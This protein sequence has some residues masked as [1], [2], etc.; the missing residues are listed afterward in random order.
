LQNKKKTYSQKATLRRGDLQ[1]LE[2]RAKRYRTG[3][4]KEGKSRKMI[5]A[6]SRKQPGQWGEEKS[7]EY[8]CFPRN[9]EEGGKKPIALGKKRA[10]DF[11]MQKKT[12]HSGGK[13]KK[14]TAWVHRKKKGKANLLRQDQAQKR[15]KTGRTSGS[16]MR[17]EEGGKTLKGEEDLQADYP[18][19]KKKNKREE[20]GFRQPANFKKEGEG[21]TKKGTCLLALR[22]LIQKKRKKG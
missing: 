22:P 19:I 9:L 12:T 18:N 16:G 4:R 14:R 2:A 13:R 7:D 8:S 10:L 20:R 15:T 5:F 21:R 6:D 17:G 11:Q 3:G 1:R